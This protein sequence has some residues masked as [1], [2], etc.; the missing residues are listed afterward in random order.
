MRQTTRY[1][2]DSAS[3]RAALV[4]K[5]NTA[6]SQLG[7]DEETWA[8]VKSTHGNCLS[9]AASATPPAT[10]A[11][12]QAIL[13]HA[14]TCG[15]KDRYRQRNG[16]LSQPL[17]QDAQAKR[18]RALWLEM[19]TLGAVQDAEETALCHWIMTTKKGAVQTGH[20]TTSISILPTAD[21]DN[22][23]GRLKQWRIRW[24]KSGILACPECGK[25]FTPTDK[26]VR[27]VGKI[28]CEAH[29]PP[30]TYQFVPPASTP[31]PGKGQ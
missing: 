18:L 3:Q 8:A 19:H 24:L 14:R 21:I 5:I 26:Q 31:S 4:K 27:A 1:P 10:V 2:Q 28:A 29:I 15:F 13:D 16:T 17:A 23:I 6:R 12:L 11:Q 22:A 30:I 7:W 25:A 20:V 9:I